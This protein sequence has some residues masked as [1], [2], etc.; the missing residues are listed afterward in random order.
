MNGQTNNIRSVDRQT[1]EQLDRPASG[2]D[3]QVH[4]NSE[5]LSTKQSQHSPL[6]FALWH[7]AQS[8]SKP[9][10]PLLSLPMF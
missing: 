4:C 8:Y 9:E 6:M 7:E 10:H 1:A 2:E 5:L 3:V